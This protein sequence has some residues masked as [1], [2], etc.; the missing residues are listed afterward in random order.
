MQSFIQNNLYSKKNKFL[1]AQ[2]F[3]K[4]KIINFIFDKL[5]ERKKNTLFRMSDEKFVEKCFSDLAS[6]T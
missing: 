1:E 6:F 2:D 4:T 3:Q 5:S